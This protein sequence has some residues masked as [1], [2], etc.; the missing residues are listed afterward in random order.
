MKFLFI[1]SAIIILLSCKDEDKVSK[2][3][4]TVIVPQYKNRT[5]IDNIAEYNRVDGPFIGIGATKSKQYERFETIIKFDERKL[6][7]LT[8]HKSPV[9]RVYAFDAL[10]QKNYS[11]MFSIFE[12]H[13]SDTTEFVELSGCLEFTKTVNADFLQKLEPLM[14]SH[15]KE[16]YFKE[17]SSCYSKERWDLLRR[18][19]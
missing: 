5:V 6:I 8:R 1:C 17:V 11:K 4:E 16:K 9:V 18:F 12:E 7:E 15:Q 19:W 2:L 13:A 3:D 10:F 14:T